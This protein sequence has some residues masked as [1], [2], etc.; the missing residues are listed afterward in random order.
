MSQRVVVYS[1]LALA[2]LIVVG[3]YIYTVILTT[4]QDV[5]VQSSEQENIET[6]PTM[7]EAERLEM[8]ESLQT[9]PRMTEEEQR[10]MLEQLK[11][12]N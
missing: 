8:L 6:L 10:Q 1:L 7:T 3:I 9:A 5:P 2:S 12:I 4:G 11:N